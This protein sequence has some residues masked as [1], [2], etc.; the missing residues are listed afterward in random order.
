MRTALIASLAAA[1]AFAGCKGGDSEDY[2]TENPPAASFQI[3]PKE[4]S[5]VIGGSQQFTATSGNSNVIWMIAGETSAGT[6]SIDSNGK[7]DIARDEEAATI[8]VTAWLKADLDKQDTAEVTITPATEVNCFSNG[9]G[10][11]G[12]A[13]D[14]IKD[15]KSAGPLVI[16]LAAAST[17]ESV[18]LGDSAQD[19][20]G[21]L[22]LT[23][24]DS[25][26]NV[27]IDGGNRTITLSSTGTVPVITVGTGVTLTLWNITLTGSTGNSASLVKVKDGGRLVLAEGAVITGNTTTGVTGSGVHVASNGTLEMSGGIISYNTGNYNGGGVF[28][29]TNGSLKMSG[30]IISY[31][32]GNYGGGVYVN[33]GKLEMSGGTISYNTGKANGG[34]VYVN[35]GTLEMS[36]DA[37]VSGNTT[38]NA[39]GGGVYLDNGALKIEGN[40]NISNNKAKTYGGGISTE[41]NSTITMKDNAKISNNE[42]V[43]DEGGGVVVYKA[44]F[45]MEGGTIFG[46]KA[47]KTGGGVYVYKDSGSIFEMTGGIIYGSG[48]PGKDADDNDLKNTAVISGAAVYVDNGGV[49]NVDTTDNTVNGVEQGN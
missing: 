16:K 42:A 33:G 17:E 4:A 36:G 49:S 46:N 15:Y 48:E 22:V 14:L 25:P 43:S 45:T 44:T 47:A 7:L 40:A 13:I 9:T 3:D 2:V 27:I 18:N 32:T 21:G 24:A 23:A 1:L 29:D 19:I 12:S 11:E 39:S 26:A 38:N 8:T 5:I 35:G 28:V 37:V 31:N 6:T 20:N 41:G 34:G 10:E 30:G